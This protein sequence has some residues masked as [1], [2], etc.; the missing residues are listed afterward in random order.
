MV[1]EAAVAD[2]VG[3]SSASVDGAQVLTS[4][5]GGD[6]GYE[7]TSKMVAEAALLLALRRETLPRLPRGDGRSGAGLMTP[8]VGLGLPYLQ[9]LHARGV[10]F[11]EHPIPPGS[12]VAEEIH[13]L[14]VRDPS[15]V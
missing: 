10:Q 13:R 5:S 2:A 6:P 9:I 8:A 7:E 4:V 12:T 3:G 11:N 1:A 14:A 15:Q